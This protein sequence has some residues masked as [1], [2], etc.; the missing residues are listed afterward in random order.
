[1]ELLSQKL[2][3]LVL[4]LKQ[5]NPLRL[6]EE[7]IEDD[8]GGRCKAEHRIQ[9]IRVLNKAQALGQHGYA[10]GQDGAVHQV[11]PLLAPLLEQAPGSRVE[12]AAPAQGRL[13]RAPQLGLA[14]LDLGQP[15]AGDHQQQQHPQHALCH[16]QPV[17]PALY[18]LLAGHQQLGADQPNYVVQK[19]CGNAR[20]ERQAVQQPVLRG[21]LCLAYLFYLAEP[22]CEF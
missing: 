7:H 20:A 15:A 2:V 12:V 8:H 22:F 13:P 4:L 3:L 19:V 5:L 17:F 14:G 6:L 16:R 18:G 10:G 9:G 11:E 1:V 21:L